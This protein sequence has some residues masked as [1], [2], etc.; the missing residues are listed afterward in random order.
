VTSRFWWGLVLG[1]VG[2]WYLYGA[3]SAPSTMVGV[4]GLT[5]KPLRNEGRLLRGTGRDR[6]SYWPFGTTKGR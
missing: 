6:P 5:P 4:G 1:A 2:Y 3:G